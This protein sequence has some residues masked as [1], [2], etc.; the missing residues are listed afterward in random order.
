MDLGSS[1]YQW[2]H[3]FALNIQ[4]CLVVKNHTNRPATLCSAH[5]GLQ[6][7]CSLEGSILI[8]RRHYYCKQHV[9]SNISI[10]RCSTNR[11]KHTHHSL[12]PRVSCTF[13]HHSDTD[14]I[15]LGALDVSTLRLSSKD[16]SLQFAGTADCGAEAGK[17][18]RG[19]VTIEEVH[20]P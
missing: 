12:I 9:G 3:W 14:M 17:L 18:H 10:H 15:V 13:L 8:P 1:L 5:T 2:L 7:R 11:L 4:L 16:M 20:S 19:L 6:S